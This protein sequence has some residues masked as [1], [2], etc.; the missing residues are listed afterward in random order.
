MTPMILM[1]LLPQVTPPPEVQEH[2]LTSLEKFVEDNLAQIDELQQQQLQD[3]DLALEGRLVA[4]ETTLD[5]IMAIGSLIAVVVVGQLGI[6]LRTR[7]GSNH[8]GK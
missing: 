3:R 1:L 6:G 8:R 7:L 5:Y 4:M 2:R